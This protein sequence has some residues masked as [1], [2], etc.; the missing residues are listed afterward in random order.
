[1]IIKEVCVATKHTHCVWKS[2]RCSS[3]L[4][5]PLSMLSAT[6][7]NASL[8][9]SPKRCLRLAKYHIKHISSTSI[10]GFKSIN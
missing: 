7:L 5:I 10:T 2:V 6:P 8:R 9:Y 3:P 4:S 1:M